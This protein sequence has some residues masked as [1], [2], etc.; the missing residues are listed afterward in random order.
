MHQTVN[1]TSLAKNF[2]RRKCIASRGKQFRRGGLQQ[3]R[4]YTTYG[5]PGARRAL[6]PTSTTI[7]P[8]GM[9]LG[10]RNHERAQSSAHQT[11]F[12]HSSQM[13]M[14]LTNLRTSCMALYG[15]A[16]TCPQI[17]GSRLHSHEELVM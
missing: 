5:I 13:D 3:E 17:P 6:V 2:V 14:E 7:L 1:T 8:A 10:L 4:R 11:S 15:F 16:S 9:V 12:Q